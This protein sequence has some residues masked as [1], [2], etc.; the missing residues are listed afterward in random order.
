MGSPLYFFKAPDQMHDQADKISTRCKV[1]L[2]FQE[3]ILRY[4]FTTAC[5]PFPY[6]VTQRDRNIESPLQLQ[7]RFIS[8]PPVRL[9]RHV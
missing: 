4:S 5:T 8:Y 1:I 3:L 2:R 6:T 7:M 9:H